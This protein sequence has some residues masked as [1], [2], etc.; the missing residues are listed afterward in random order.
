MKRLNPALRSDEIPPGTHEIKVPEGSAK[1]FEQRFPSAGSQSIDQEPKALQSK[2]RE[3]KAH[4]PKI[5]PMRE[6]APA[7]PA[8]AQPQAKIRQIKRHT[9][10]KGETLSALARKYDVS[11]AE[12]KNANKLKNDTI[13]PGQKLVIP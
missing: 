13:A 3:S 9:V 1:S 11:I 5:S 4:E 10:Q 12:I 8:T 2:A 6:K 7:K